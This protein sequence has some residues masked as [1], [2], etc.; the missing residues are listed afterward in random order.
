MYGILTGYKGLLVIDFDTKALW[1]KLKGKFP[2]TYTS[3]SMN[4]K[5]PHLYYTV[6][7][8]KSFKILDLNKETLADIQGKGKQVIGINSQLNEKKVTVW[9]DLPITKLKMGE[10]E[11]IF[12]PYRDISTIRAKTNGIETDP[13]CQEIKDKIKIPEILSGMGV[14]INLSL[15]HI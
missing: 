6:D 13:I 5:L 12:K 9:K 10:I 11:A 15:I 2:E 7:E 8:P 14:D 4:K 3:L 1:D